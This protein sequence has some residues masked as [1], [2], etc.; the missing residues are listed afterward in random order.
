MLKGLGISSGLA[1]AKTLVLKKEPLSVPGRTVS[2]TASEINFFRK[3]HE[4]VLLENHELYETARRR[5]SRE[6]AA[7]FLAH[8]E[9]L[10]DETSLIAPIINSIRDNG[11]NAA[12]AADRQFQQI[13]SLFEDMEDEYM[14]ARASDMRDIRERL[15]RHLLG[16][17]AP[18]LSRLPENTIIV[19]CEITPSDTAGM[20][21]DK[22]AGFITEI[23]GFTSHS[24]IIARSREIPAV[25]QIMNAVQVFENG[26]LILLDGTKG[27]VDSDI[28]EEKRKSFFLAKEEEKRQRALWASFK[29]KPT[30]TRDGHSLSLLANIGSPDDI[31]NAISSDAEGIGLF[32]TEFLYMNS[33]SLPDE[34]TQFEAY[35]YVLRKMAPKPVIIRTLDIG[36]DKELPALNLPKEDNPFLGYRA[37]RICLDRPDLFR[38]QLRALLRASI[39]GNLHI[40]FPMISALQELR[41]SKELLEEVKQKLLKD[42]IPF[43]SSIPVG[44]MI[45]VP[46]AAV[47]ADDFAK[48]C[49][50]FSIGTNDLTQYTL[51]ADRGN[52]KISYL[53]DTSHPAVLHLIKNT[54]EAAHNNN[55]MCG[56]CGEAAGD[57]SLQP[58]LI[59][60][61]IDELSMSP[62]SILKSRMQISNLMY[63]A[64]N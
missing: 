23:G 55:I 26:T 22:I 35:R 17:K 48:E 1:L 14:K 45:E 40:M 49:D 47:M 61:G 42:K 37:I 6:D 19:A 63:K 64:G 21:L 38:I 30:V 31:D 52:S 25:S 20:N 24:A 5:L 39:Y 28:T 59:Q 36:G 4:Q 44:M 43:A 32:R 41:R 57:A 58:F 13:I 51:A 62:S 29:G 2:D 60:Y 53:Y 46:A 12:K 9:I 15:L 54:I 34:N 11:W 16:I 56:I 50:F 10:E 3:I 7:I 8:R 27:T 33:A 18:D